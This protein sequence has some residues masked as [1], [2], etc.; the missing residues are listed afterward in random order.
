MYGYFNNSINNNKRVKTIE[1]SV[2]YQI[3][4]TYIPITQTLL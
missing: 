4:F 2:P 3:Y 1:G